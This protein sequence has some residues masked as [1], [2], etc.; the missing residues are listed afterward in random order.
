MPAV[1]R[2]G[3]GPIR[4]GRLVVTVAAAAFALLHGACRADD[5]KEACAA[6]RQVRD[7]IQSLHLFVDMDVTPSEMATKLKLLSGPQRYTV[8]WWLTPDSA[9]WSEVHGK[10]AVDQAWSDK[11]LRSLARDQVAPQRTHSYGSVQSMPKLNSGTNPWRNALWRLPNLLLTLDEA[12]AAE[13]ASTS[14]TWEES[15]G[16]RM[17]HV[18]LNYRR[19]AE[20]EVWLSSRRNFV[21]VRQTYRHL[22]QKVASDD[23]VV[24]FREW[25]PGVFFPEHTETRR[26]V[27]FDRL[28]MTEQT[29]FRVLEMN[30]AL[31]AKKFELPFPPNITV[32]DKVRGQQYRTG[33]DGKPTATA[34]PTPPAVPEPDGEEVVPVRTATWTYWATG[35]AVATGVLWLVARARTA[36]A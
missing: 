22:E 11:E 29:K 27:G 14:T 28:L 23:T 30:A 4:Q 9:R 26:F 19:E 34:P 15:D 2:H 32:V 36:R 1:P 31:P 17:L 12:C 33:P 18:K 3:V 21:P 24:R 10:H 20:V 16:D 5:L 35:L 13:G 8:E 7:S 6:F 25:Q